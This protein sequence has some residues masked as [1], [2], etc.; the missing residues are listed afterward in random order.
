MRKKRTMTIRRSIDD[1]TELLVTQHTRGLGGVCYAVLLNAN[2]DILKVADFWMNEELD[3]VDDYELIN[4]L[5]PILEPFE[6][7]LL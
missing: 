1:G 3:N 6:A 5:S 2:G 4:H 7:G